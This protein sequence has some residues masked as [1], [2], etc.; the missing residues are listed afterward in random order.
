[1]MTLDATAAIHTVKQDGTGNYTTIQ[2]A[3]NA[4]AA[5]DTV[6]VWPG[7]Y[8]ENINYYSKRITVA[9]LNLTM[10]DPIYIQSTI[11]DGNS[12]GSCVVV[13][14]IST[15]SGVLHGFT[16]MNGTGYSNFKRG[17]G[18]YLYQSHFS[19]K[20][21]IIKDCTASAGG[22]VFCYYYTVLHLAGTKI[23]NNRSSNQ[24]GGIV[25]GWESNVVFDPLNRNSVF[26]NHGTMGCDISK[27]TSPQLEI[28]LDTG[29]TINPDAYFIY[30]Y[31]ELGY[32]VNNISLDINSGKIQQVNANIYVSPGGSDLNSGLTPNDPLQTISFAMKKILPDT[33]EIKTI[34]LV[35]G[36]YSATSN[37]EIFPII[38]RAYILLS[39]TGKE[40]TIIDAEHNYQLFYSNILTSNFSIEKIHFK[41]G[42][43]NQLFLL[44]IGGINLT[45]NTDVKLSDI[46]V[47]ETNSRDRP[48]INSN[49]SSVTIDKAFV[50][51][52]SGGTAFTLYNTGQ[53]H[54][55]F[56]VTNTIVKSNLPGQTYE[57]GYGGAVSL[58][59]SL[60]YPNSTSCALMN[61]E[62]SENT[63]LFDPAWGTSKAVCGLA[64]G[65]NVY[66]DVVNTTI[67]NNE[68]VNPVNNAQVVA[69][70]GAKIN[71][72]NSI[73]HGV[74]DY[75]IFLGDGLPTSY[76]STINISHSNVKGGEGNIQNWNN[77][78][79]LNWLSGNI[80]DDPLWS[81]SELHYYDLLEGSPSINTGT[82]MYETGMDYPFIKTE[83]GKH[84]LYTLTG[85]TIHLPATDLA[86][87][88]RISG[89]RIDMGAYEFQET[90]TNQNMYRQT[91]KHGFRVHP[92]PFVSNA[93]ISFKTTRDHQ[94]SINVINMKGETM[95]TIASNRFPTGEYRLIYDGHDDAGFAL[96]PGTYL[97]CLY[98]DGILAGSEKLVRAKR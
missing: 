88:P 92:N 84:I 64:C 25:I 83:G 8:F 65:Q 4:A 89:G 66:V 3:I 85:D 91:P 26:L 47:T 6:L 71:F 74:E 41:R 21:C 96:D 2:S 34:L 49:S 43:D 39:G 69:H 72:Y 42:S 87:N 33:N 98:L 46:M 52:N 37:Q 59:G 63:L 12:N 45:E 23:Y 44:G 15:P 56:L 55:D 95:R 17:G 54:R 28:I 75:E 7:T 76:I 73:I 20:N 48:G 19:I 16:I 93:F 81:G 77:I 80:A 10:G 86:G 18:I 94:V 82:P 30:S 24:G 27:A 22:G 79:N 60:S 13:T 68:I 61:V 40:N 31:N 53:I 58:S 35:P 14:N 90:T 38:P 67:G 36:I 62:I 50:I 32:P 78:H 57:D 5:G 70:E 29:T 97:V 9:S 51:D 11:I 1:M